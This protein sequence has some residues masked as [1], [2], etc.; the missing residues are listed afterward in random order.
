MQA[1]HH[2]LQVEHDVNDIFADTFQRRILMQHA[3]DGHLGYSSTGHRRQENAAQR[4]TQSVAIASLKRFHDNSGMQWRERLNVD[5][6][7]F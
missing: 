1:H 6:A 4:I 5:D 7:G 3:V 2:A